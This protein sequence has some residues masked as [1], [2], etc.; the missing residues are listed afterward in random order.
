M[1]KFN[2]RIDDMELKSCDSHLLGLEDHETAEIVMWEF[3]R[4]VIETP[5]CYTIAYWVR[6]REGYYLKFVG[7]RPFDI[8][9]DKIAFFKLA[10]LGQ[11][12]LDEY[13]SEQEALQ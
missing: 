2:K 13:F 10:E 9:I 6:N 12:H 5:Y 3:E 11:K 7:N 4:T 8:R 1:K